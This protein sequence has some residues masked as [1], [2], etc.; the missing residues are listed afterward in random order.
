MV[1]KIIWTKNAQRD[2]FA[3]F[4]Y[5]NNRNKSNAYSRKLNEIIKESLSLI[6]NHPKIGKLTDKENVRAKVLKDYLIIYEITLKEIVV[7]TLWDCRLNPED[8]KR[9]IN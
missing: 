4:S 1:R 2:R 6:S 5:W 9:I 8:L 3:I 7:L